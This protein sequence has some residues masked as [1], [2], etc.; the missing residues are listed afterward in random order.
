[1]SGELATDTEFK[2]LL[3]WYMLNSIHSSFHSF[4]LQ[5][6]CDPKDQGTKWW[7]YTDKIDQIPA[8]RMS[9]AWSIWLCGDKEIMF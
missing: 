4:N 3:N 8:L 9:T 2:R 1:M 7:V 6:F 5:E